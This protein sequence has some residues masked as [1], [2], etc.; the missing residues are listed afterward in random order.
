MRGKPDFGRAEFATAAQRWRNAGWEVVSPAEL[1]CAP[2]RLSYSVNERMMED[3]SAI[4]DCSAMA[5]LPGWQASAGARAEYAYAIALDPPREVFD[6]NTG[7]PLVDEGG[8]RVCALTGSQRDRRSGKGR[9]DLLPVRAILAIARHSEGG[10]EHYGERNI[11]LG[12]PISWL[13]DS[14][15]RHLLQSM[16]TD[17]ESKSL[18]AAAWNL[19]WA[20]D[21]IERVRQGELPAELLDMRAYHEQTESD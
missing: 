16:V 5:M 4:A 2:H 3:I 20:I 19:L 15:L 10:I 13:L 6:A 9:C 14:G 8:N 7:S 12:Q 11:E 21:E 1:D 18:V 17:S